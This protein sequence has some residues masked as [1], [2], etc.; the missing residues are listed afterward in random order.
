[1]NLPCPV[2]VVP[3]IT[4]TSLQDQYSL[5]PDTIWSVLSKSYE[6]IA[7]HP[8]DLRYEEMEPTRVVPDQPF[9]IAYRE[10]I[11]EL[12]YN[13]A[14][15]PETPVPVFPFGYDWRQPLE[16][17][18]QELA[19]FVEEVI[20]RTAL[21]RHYRESDWNKERK[22]SLIGHSMGGLVITGYLER[23]GAA[24]MVDKV[25]TLAT[26]YRGSFEAVIKVT[27][28]TVNL[29]FSAPSSRERETARLTPSL[30]YLLP[31]IPGSLQPSTLPDD[32]LLYPDNWQPAVVDTLAAY[33][34]RHRLPTDPNSQ[35]QA[36][37]LFA[38][39]LKKSR[40]HRRRID[41]FDPAAAGLQID[42]WLV[43]AGVNTETRVQMEIAQ[44][45]GKTQFQLRSKHRMDQWENGVNAQSK[46]LTGD[47]TV[48]LEGALP[49]FIPA[50]KVVCVTPGD[51]GYWELQDRMV[52]GG[53]GLHG[54]L[55]NMNLIHRLIVR[56][57]TGRSDAYENTWGRRVPGAGWDLPLPLSEK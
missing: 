1:M 52:S 33:M 46:R 14:E 55:P 42:D 41:G 29:G 11:E 13:L 21:M 15:K 4:A 57:L 39:L 7:L 17:T 24:S 20:A 54:V 27:T 5:S 10:V 22:V 26:P 50:E 23:Y 16:T 6:R 45:G 30:Y 49:P 2:I 12:R 40:N 53:A 44:P 34:E 18:E 19:G 31:S 28:G 48:P 8:N 35:K 36:E 3:G 43:I 37:D 47:G 9:E 25:V 32:A 38:E 51:Y 56:F